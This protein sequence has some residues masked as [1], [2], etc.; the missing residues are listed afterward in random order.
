M[1]YYV[2]SGAL[3][4]RLRGGMRPAEDSLADKP[5]KDKG[6][7]SRDRWEGTLME[8]EGP[9]QCKERGK[10]LKVNTALAKSWRDQ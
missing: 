2:S 10:G 8:V 4:S 3:R 9:R 1:D 7:G 5:V 6:Q